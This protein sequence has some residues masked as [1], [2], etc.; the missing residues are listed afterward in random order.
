MHEHNHLELEPDP[1]Q[2][3]IDD[4]K[5]THGVEGDNSFSEMVALL[6]REVGLIRVQAEEAVDV[7]Q[8]RGLLAGSAT[9]SFTATEWQAAIIKILEYEYQHPALTDLFAVRYVFNDPLLDDIIGHLNP[10]QFAKRISVSKEAVNKAVLRAQKEFGLPIRDGQRGQDAR[11]NM[12]KKRLEQLG[13][14]LT[15]DEDR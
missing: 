5:H 10:A 1:F 8:A 14:N 6:Q 12:R 15:T 2:P 13:K 3:K 7:M 9:R 11:E 4:L